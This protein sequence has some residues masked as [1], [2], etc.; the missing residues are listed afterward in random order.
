MLLCVRGGVVWWSHTH[1]NT[2]RLRWGSLKEP[3]QAFAQLPS[4]LVSE[5]VRRHD[6]TSKDA[7]DLLSKEVVGKDQLLVPAVPSTKARRARYKQPKVRSALR[8]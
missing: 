7:E 3:R 2:R 5:L 1:K 6:G 4:G 8:T